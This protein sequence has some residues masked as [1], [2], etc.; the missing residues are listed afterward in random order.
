[1]SVALEYIT[2][3][4]KKNLVTLKVNIV[5]AVQ[6]TSNIASLHLPGCAPALSDWLPAS[7]SEQTLQS[8]EKRQQSFPHKCSLSL[9][10]C[11]QH[12]PSHR[13]ED[14]AE[15]QSLFDYIEMNF[16]F[17]KTVTLSCIAVLE[18]VQVCINSSVF[19]SVA[20][21][22]WTIILSF[23]PHNFFCKMFVHFSLS[24]S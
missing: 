16:H 4:I 19:I 8:Q 1:M 18:P 2:H 20:V 17:G 11:C 9:P 24:S 13:L 3:F 23:S 21:C 14:G 5:I 6:F 10:Y 15:L 7:P 12:Q 22:S